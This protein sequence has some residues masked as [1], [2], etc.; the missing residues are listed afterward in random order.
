MVSVTGKSRVVATSVML[1]A[2]FMD[3][4]DTTIINV[5]LPAIQLDL[6]ATPTQL[7]WALGGYIVA[8]AV[9]LITGGRLG[10]RFGRRTIFVIGV[11]GFTAT[12]WLASS[13][14]S[15]ELLVVARL[16]QGAFAG[17]M[18]PQVLSTIQVMYSPREREPIFGLLG[19]LGALGAVTGLIAGGWL[20][21]AD[22]FG[23]GWRT[24]FAVNIPIGIALL[25]VALLVVPNS[26]ASTPPRIDVA[27]V[28][29]GAAV[30]F[31]VVFPLTDGRAAGWPW[32][33]IAML[34]VT[35]IAV[36]G[37]VFQQK[38]AARSGI[39]LLPMRLF[40]DRGFSAGVIL[41]AISSI[42]NGGYAFVLIFYVQHSL[43]FSALSSGLTILPLAVGSALAAP[44]AAAL[45]KHVSGR[46]LVA[47]G[48]AV[49]AG[50]FA[51]VAIVIAVR[52]PALTGWDLAIAMAVAGAGM[53]LLMMP[54]M[55]LT[56]ATV[57]VNDAGAASGTVTTFT[58]I[59]MVLGITLA[60][61][62]YFALDATVPP[63]SL[64]VTTALWVPVVAYLV[65][66]VTAFA[67]PGRGGV[68]AGPTT[69][70]GK[71]RSGRS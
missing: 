7:E 61:A 4:V 63:A 23:A 47:L 33:M 8:F 50:A 22:P 21:T 10:D 42:G 11:L 71:R 24:I 64:P 29:L 6:G 30:V 46:C 15:P 43:D 67:L 48:G 49:Q 65:T 26:R 17:V 34:G 3:L 37:F 51:A 20:V 45:A 27:G 55:G 5:A 44:F 12:S 59:G 39:A 69:P 16:A 68:I 52:G 41:H 14:Q 35:P 56:L 40:R 28:L 58:Q 62:V 60:A 66:A 13:A 36:A 53:M 9:L 31:L 70:A 1:I 32:W 18:V 25:V 2:M 38:H 57:P 54:L 19:A